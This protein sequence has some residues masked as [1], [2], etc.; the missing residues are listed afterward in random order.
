[1]Y[2]NNV[3]TNVIP[4]LFCDILNLLKCCDPY[5]PTFTA[6]SPKHTLFVI[7]EGR[8]SSTRPTA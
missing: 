8:I 1:M 3:L 7:P 5:A 2:G 6:I 4:N